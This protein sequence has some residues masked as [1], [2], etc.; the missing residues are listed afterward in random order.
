MSGK[1]YWCT[2]CNGPLLSKKCYSCGD[3]GKYCASD[4]KPVFKKEKEMYERFLDIDLPDNLFRNRNRIIMDG[5]TLFRYKV[6]GN[7][8]SSMEDIYLIKSKIQEHFSDNTFRDKMVVANSLVLDEKVKESITFIKKVADDY[9]D[10]PMFISFS[11]GKDSVATALLVK[12]AKIGDIPLFFSDTT[13]EYPETYEFIEQFAEKH[14]FRLIKDP[15]TQNFYRSERD[16]FEICDELGPP[17]MTYRWCCTVFKSYP[18]NEFY[19]TMGKDILTFDGVRSAESFSRK[20]YS[21]ISRVKKIPRQLATY[22]ILY[23]R[24]ADVWFYTLFNKIDYNPLYDL[25]HTRVG[26]WVCPAASPSNCF[27]RKYTHPNLWVKFEKVLNDY[28]EKYGKGENWITGNYWR[29]RR[30]KKDKVTAV[31]CQQPCIKKQTFIYQFEE[32]VNRQMLE[33]L[34]P[35]GDITI[36]DSQFPSFKVGTQNP[37]EA[38]GS[39]GGYEVKASFNPENFPTNKKMFEKQLIK[40][41]NCVGCGGCVGVCPHDAISIINKQFVIDAKKCDNINC[42]KCINSKFVVNGCV[43]ISYKRERKVIG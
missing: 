33:F 11:G 34:K 41:L 5:N 43:A 39:I 27:M 8:L 28:A 21:E 40:A 7:K 37:F 17:S 22:P 9:K 10:M 26:C 19:K 15:E 30:P 25:G 12:E 31:T 32:P 1:I 6:N 42:Q 18:V 13:L 4:L 14:K 36:K 16:F 35:F 29:L 23:W 38:S 2:N 3:D 24:E 20:N